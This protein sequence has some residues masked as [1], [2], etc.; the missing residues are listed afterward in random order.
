MRRRSSSMRGGLL[1]APKIHCDAAPGVR[2]E[3]DDAG[4]SEALG[5]SFRFHEWGDS[6]AGEVG[7]N[8]LAATVPC[9]KHALRVCE[10]SHRSKWKAWRPGLP[11]M[12][13]DSNRLHV[14]HCVHF[15][16]CAGLCRRTPS[17]AILL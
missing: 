17:P 9:R 1:V 4:D 10:T 3:D 16:A 12:P 11:P 15:R 8:P 2:I 7:K 13:L 14:P 5:N 6:A